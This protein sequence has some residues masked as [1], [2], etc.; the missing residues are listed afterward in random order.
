MRI[1]QIDLNDK[2]DVKKFIKFPFELYKKNNLWVPPLI[3]SE[4]KKLNPNEHPYYLHSTAEFYLVEDQRNKALGRIALL[5]NTRHNKYRNENAG[6]FGFF[7]LVEDRKVAKILLDTAEEWAL[8]KGFNQLIGPKGLLNTESGGVLVEGFEHRPALNVPYNFPYYGTFLEEAGYV[9]ER[10]SLSGYIHIPSIEIPDRVRK[11]AERVMER[12][13][14]Y[15]KEFKTK[16][17]MWEMV[18]EAKSV[19]NDSFRGGAGFVEMTDEEFALAAEELISI[20]DPRLIKVVMKEN[21]VIGYLFTYHDVSAGLRRAKG[22]LF[23]FGWLHL[24]IE[25]KRTK[26]LNVNGLGILPEYQGRGGNAVMYAALEDTVRSHFN[27][28]H[29]DTVFIGEENFPSFS[30]NETMGVKWYKRHRMYH[31]DL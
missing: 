3:S 30:D 5:H 9:K 18:E 4:M 15:I 7:D 25:Q 29:I 28:E 12:R 23:P 24:L 21:K 13:G 26:W 31:K 10:D 1:R 11:I 16:E 27:F 17:E 22:R 2:G 19:L 14:F 20:A 8:Q 6:L